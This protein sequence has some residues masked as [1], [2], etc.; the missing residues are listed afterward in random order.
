MTRSEG[1]TK[2]S[3]A[4]P[5][6]TGEV[7]LNEEW[8]DQPL[9]WRRP[10]KIFVCAH[11]DLFA[12]A[13]PDEWIDKVFAVMALAP[14]HTFQV[15]TKRARRM[16]EYFTTPYRH[17]VHEL[18]D[19][20]ASTRRR[21][22]SNPRG[23]VRSVPKCRR[24]PEPLPAWQKAQSARDGSFRWP[25]PNVWLGVSAE[26]QARAHQRVPDLLATPAAARFVSAEPLLGPDQLPLDAPG[27]HG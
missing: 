26:D 22:C 21:A 1:L 4:G 23:H 15:L 5:V 10:R 18:A 14:Q 8:L 12:E 3:K 9:R 17:G 24:P 27:G 7:R 13:V 19:G 11:G 16:R 2:D 25:L 6:W 20:S